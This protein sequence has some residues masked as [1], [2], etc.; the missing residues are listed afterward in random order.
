MSEIKTNFEFPRGTDNT[1]FLQRLVQDL[2]KNFKALKDS[3]DNISINSTTYGLDGIE[4]SGAFSFSTGGGVPTYLTTTQTHTHNFG[5]TPR[6]FIVTDITCTAPSSVG[7]SVSS[8]KRV[9]WT[10]TQ[11]SIRIEAIDLS[12]GQSI[13]GTYKILVLR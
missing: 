13:S 6:G 8:I 9:S 1:K 4:F 2:S 3:T 5:S 11:I 7:N 10:S 12:A